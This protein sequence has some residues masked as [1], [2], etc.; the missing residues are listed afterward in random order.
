MRAPCGQQLAQQQSMAML[1]VLAVA[2]FLSV[3]VIPGQGAVALPVAQWHPSLVEDIRLAE[4]AR[5]IIGLRGDI[6]PIPASLALEP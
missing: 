4:H 6:V 5:E 3:F 1:F 2:L